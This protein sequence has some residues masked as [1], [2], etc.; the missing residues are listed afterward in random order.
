MNTPPIPGPAAP[1]DWPTITAEA[2]LPLLQR[3]IM[4]LRCGFTPVYALLGRFLPKLKAA[5]GRPPFF[6]DD[7]PGSSNRDA[8]STAAHFAISPVDPAFLASTLRALEFP[9][10]RVSLNALAYEG[11]F[12][13]P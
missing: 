2:R 6:G 11:S 5:S 10:D 4:L 12:P 7:R 1:V 8:R 9:S 3:S 13:P